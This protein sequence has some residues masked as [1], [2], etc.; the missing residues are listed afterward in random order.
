M[1]YFIPEDENSNK[2]IFPP[3]FQQEKRSFLSSINCNDN[4]HV[5]VISLKQKFKMY[6]SIQLLQ[7]QRDALLQ[8]ELRTI[9][10]LRMHNGGF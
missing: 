3:L 7:L 10:E 8:Q 5:C 1:Q 9:W 2:S 6:S 4:S